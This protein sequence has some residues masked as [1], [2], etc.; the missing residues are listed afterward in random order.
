MKESGVMPERNVS[1]FRRS[2]RLIIICILIAIIFTVSTYAWFIGM[3]SVHVTPFD[4]EIAVTDSLMLSLDGA[5]WSPSVTISKEDLDEDPDFPYEGHSNSW[6]GVGLIP[7]ST[8]GEMDVEA[9]R[10]MLYEKASFTPTPGGYRLM[11][12]RVLNYEQDADEQEGY[13]VFDLF[14]K[15]F[16]G[17]Q[18]ISDLEPLDEEAIYLTIDSEVTVSST[19]GVPGTGIENSVR[20]AFAQI[21]RVAGTTTEQA[22]ITG[23]TCTS[24]E[25]VTGICRKAQIWEPNDRKHVDAAISWYQTSCRPRKDEGDDVTDPTSFELEQ[26]CGTVVDGL[27]YPTYAVKT[28][29]ASSDNIDIYDGSAYNGY[30]LDLETS[31]LY[32]YSYFTDSMKFLRGVQRPPFMTLAPNSITKVRVYVYI[33]GQDIDNYDFAQI[34]KRITV[35][36]G[37]TK[38]RFTEDDIEYGGPDL[39]QGQGPEAEDKTP[40]V[41]IL[42]GDQYVELTVGETYEELGATAA[43]NIDGVI[44]VDDIVTDGT[45][46]TDVPGIYEVYYIAHDV[47]GNRGHVVRYVTVSEPAGGGD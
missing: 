45:V 1:R 24:D 33:E 29:I 15:N 12:S 11:A 32:P 17:T 6:G 46:N 16:S 41:V 5:T 39:N 36:F 10:M 28:D 14:I 18:Y 3:R 21:G 34:G 43:D 37:F 7:M 26:N 25:N 22:V 27:A 40:P 35:K 31:K 30:Q 20:V 8:V 4:I 9:S 2:Q 23:I 38:E 47:A 13:V 19:G 42:N 44:E